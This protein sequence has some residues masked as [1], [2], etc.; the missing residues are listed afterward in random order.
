MNERLIKI[1]EVAKKLGVGVDTLRRWDTTGEFKADSKS[2]GGVRFYQLSRVE[3][4]I[5]GETE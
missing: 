4:R 1:G 2:K 5:A 3:K